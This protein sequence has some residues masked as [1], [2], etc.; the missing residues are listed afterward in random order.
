MIVT[1]TTGLVYPTLVWAFSRLLFFEQAEGSIAF[2]DG[3]PVG[4]YLI[5]QNTRGSGFFHPRPSAAGSGYVGDTSSGSNAG[6]LNRSFVDTVVP[7]RVAAYRAENGLSPDRPVPASAVAASGSGL[8]PD[9]TVEDALLQ[10]PRVAQVRKIDPSILEGFI[11]RQ[12]HDK[13]W[14]SDSLSPVNVL[15][16]NIALEEERLGF[17]PDPW[18]GGSWDHR[19][20]R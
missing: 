6:P 13:G 9:I 10:A 3:E 5:A 14:E 16:L 18:V 7:D 12:A 15:A 20:V 17:S 8:D 2:C 1:A 4:S 19:H 11:W